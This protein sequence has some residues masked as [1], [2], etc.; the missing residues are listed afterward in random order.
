MA[1]AA[2]T[3][4]ILRPLAARIR[5]VLVTMIPAAAALD[6]AG[7]DRLLARV[8]E[9]LATEDPALGRQLRLFV[10]ALWWL[11]VFGSLR[12]LGGLA[13][14]R[15]EAFLLRLQDG[16]VAKLRVGLWG[17]RTLLYLGYYGDPAVQAE[18]GYRPDP[19]GWEAVP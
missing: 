8:D 18:L 5:P 17:L 14:Q 2:P 7:V 3:H 6:E 13:P 16:P 15:R 4:G 12:T 9:R 11:P 19:R 1:A 10:K